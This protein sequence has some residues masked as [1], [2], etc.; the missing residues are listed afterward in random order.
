MRNET[1][2]L[3]TYSGD[4]EKLSVENDNLQQTID[5][6][7]R[8]GNQRNAWPA[9]LDALNAKMPPGVWITQLTPAFDPRGATSSGAGDQRRP[10]GPGGNRPNRPGGP[11][12]SFELNPGAARAPGLAGYEPPT[13]QINVLVINGLYHADEKTTQ[14]GYTQ[15]SELVAALAEIPIFDIDKSKTSETLVSNFR[16]ST[17]A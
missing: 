17:S 10:G 6:A 8:L 14:V 15:L 11:N 16:A 9:V 13:T 7:V 4:I 12:A 2:S 3:Q 1:G 5:L